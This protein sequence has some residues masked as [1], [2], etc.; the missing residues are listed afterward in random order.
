MPSDLMNYLNSTLLKAEEIVY[1]SNLWAF[2]VGYTN[3]H[4]VTRL[5]RYEHTSHLVSTPISIFI[6]ASFAY[7]VTLLV[8][9]E[10][11]KYIGI[12]L[13]FW[14]AALP[15]EDD[16]EPDYTAHVYISLNTIPEKKIIEAGSKL[17]QLGLK[18]FKKKDLEMEFPIMYHFEFEP[19][20][21]ADPELGTHLKSLR[22]RVLE[23]FLSSQ[24]YYLSKDKYR[25]KFL[26]EHVYLFDKEGS[27]LEKDDEFLCNMGVENGHTVHAII[28][29]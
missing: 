8:I 4:L 5:Q 17:N 11:I 24:Q 1:S 13:G 21:Y 20:D 25:D 10:T 19:E 26:P 12:A 16:N 9:Y 18:A 15:L 2:L 7:G 3:T 27:I 23:W 6:S 14:K 29:F 22:G 28:G